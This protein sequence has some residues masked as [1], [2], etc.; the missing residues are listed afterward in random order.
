MPPM[1]KIGFAL[2]ITIALL[3]AAMAFQLAIA[4]GQ[5]IKRRPP[6]DVLIA[7]LATPTAALPMPASVPVSTSVKFRMAPPQRDW[8]LQFFNKQSQWECFT[9]GYDNIPN[10][11]YSVS[12]D[13]ELG[14]IIAFAQPVAMQ[15]YLRGA[16]PNPGYDAC[17]SA[18][19]SAPDTELTVSD[20][21]LIIYGAGNVNPGPTPPGYGANPAQSLETFDDL[22]YQAPGGGW[23]TQMLVSVAAAGV[24]MVIL[25]S[26]A[27]LMI[28]I[29]VLPVSAYGMALIGYGSYWYVT[30]AVFFMAL[31]IAAFAI[32]IRRPG[33]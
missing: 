7:Y 6:A 16:A 17:D 10:H 27:G 31:S 14:R 33:G 20:T 19:V 2:L 32:I 11:S 21:L 15:I 30:V 28:G 5:E 9:A 22:L 26:M 3:A 18:H 12:D 4:E 24:V 25:R 8:R 29:L 13:P 1:P 23:T